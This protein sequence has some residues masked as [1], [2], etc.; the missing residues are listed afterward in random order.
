MR[1]DQF[2]LAVEIQ[3]NVFRNTLNAGIRVEKKLFLLDFVLQEEE[4]SDEMA[5]M[6]DEKDNRNES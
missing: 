6:D 2:Q 5:M 1:G 3:N 4:I